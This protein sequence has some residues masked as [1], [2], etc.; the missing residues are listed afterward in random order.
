MFQPR[1]VNVN[2]GSL[3]GK[4]QFETVLKNVEIGKESGGKLV[5]N[6]NGAKANGALEGLTVH[7]VIFTDQP[8]DSKIMKRRFLVRLLL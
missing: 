2:H 5:L 4:A 6:E 8:E 7:P 1:D 3:T